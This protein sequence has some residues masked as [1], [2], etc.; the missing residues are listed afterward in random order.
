MF[1][2]SVPSA[3]GKYILDPSV[4][5]SSSYGQSSYGP[6][7]PQ[8]FGAQPSAYGN[9]VPNNSQQY[10]QFNTQPFNQAPSIPMAQPSILNPPAANTFA[11]GLPPIETAQPAMQYDIQRNPTPPPGWN[12][13]PVLKSSR[14]VSVCSSFN[15]YK[16]IIKIER[17]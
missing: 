3:R 9:V 5:S 11:T 16:R 2:G 12:D 6:P 1:I 7:Q 4:Q 14:P 8:T 13:P 17:K 15:D 10:N